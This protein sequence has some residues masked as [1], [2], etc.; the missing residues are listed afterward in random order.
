MRVRYSLF[1]G[2]TA[3]GLSPRVQPTDLSRVAYVQHLS[4]SG[5]DV[6]RGLRDK[7]T[8]FSYGPGLRFIYS[9]SVEHIVAGLRSQWMRVQDAQ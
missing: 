7:A 5:L 8:R 2:T 3:R 4:Y 1:V 9:P 6:E